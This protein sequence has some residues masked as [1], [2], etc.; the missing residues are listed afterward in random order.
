[1]AEYGADSLRLY[2]M[3]MGPLEATKPWSMDGVNGVHGFLNRVWRMIIDERSEELR[4]NAAVNQLPE[5]ADAWGLLAQVERQERNPQGTV[6][7][8]CHALTSPLCFGARPRKKLL[9][10]LQRIKESEV[11]DSGDPFWIR[12]HDVTLAEGLKEND[13][14][15]VLEELVEQY[16]ERGEGVRA[17]CLRIVTGEMMS[18]ETVSFRD[19][20]NWTSDDYTSKLRKD[21]E[22]AGLNA[23]LSAF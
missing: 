16:H 17:V 20:Y 2:E 6:D 3:F 22:R 10:W 12:R 8:I 15:R 21:C 18:G 5:Y 9:H 19:R 13:D 11:S 4:L 23:R 14:Y 7:A 1:M